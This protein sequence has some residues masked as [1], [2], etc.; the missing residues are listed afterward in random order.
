MN[1]EKF[2]TGSVVALLGKINTNGV[3]ET[4]DF[5][6]ATYP[7]QEKQMDTDRDEG[8]V[9]I[10]GGLEF[11]NEKEKTSTQILLKTLI[12]LM[13]SVEERLLMSKVKRVIIGGNSIVD[14]S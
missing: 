11:C 10:V 12:G 13:G 6:Y 5:T 1:P 8:Y 9:C 7:E 2:L 4:E 14:L 3:F